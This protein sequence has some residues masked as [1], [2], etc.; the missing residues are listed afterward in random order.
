M[1]W[2]APLVQPAPADIPHVMHYGLV[3]HIGSWTFDK[4]WYFHFDAHKC[5]PWDLT[6][7][8]PDGGI[9]PPPPHPDK[10]SKKVGPR[11]TAGKLRGGM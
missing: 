1:P 7:E 5:P 3:Y 9:F 10:L 11:I 8:K 2:H 6:A 4:H